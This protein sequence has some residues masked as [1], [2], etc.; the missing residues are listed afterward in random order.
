MRPQ[1]PSPRER[2]AAAE[3]RPGS[4]TTDSSTTMTGASRTALLTRSTCAATAAA[5]PTGVAV[6][7]PADNQVRVSWNTSPG[8]AAYKV[9]RK[10]GTCASTEP[11]ASI[12]VVAAPGTTFLDTTVEGSVTYAYAV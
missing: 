5:P 10:T 6:T 3:S 8:A 2:P 4:P 12:G 11:Y 9:S 7:T 1:G